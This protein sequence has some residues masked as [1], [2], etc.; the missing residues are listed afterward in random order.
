MKI[1]EIVFTE[2]DVREM[3]EEAGVPY[4]KA[5]EQ[6]VEWGRHIQDTA[7]SLC[8]EQLTSTITAGQP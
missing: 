5:L 3:A 1:I 6:A 2:E 8:H 4:E 7:T